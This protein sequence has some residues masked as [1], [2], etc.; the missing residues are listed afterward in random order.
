MLGQL[1]DIN[2]KPGKLVPERGLHQRCVRSEL[3]DRHPIARDAVCK[4]YADQLQCGWL[5]TKQD[6]S[7]YY[8]C[9][10]ELDC[11]RVPVN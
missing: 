4:V 2:L 6:D 11:N 1:E 5:V 3:K 8:L 7:V 10:A 9:L